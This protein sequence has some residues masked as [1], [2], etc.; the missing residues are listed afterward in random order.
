MEHPVSCLIMHQF[1]ILCLIFIIFLVYIVFLENG[2][3]STETSNIT[4]FNQIGF[5]FS[6]VLNLLFDWH[7]P[8]E[9][10]APMWVHR[11]R[12]RPERDIGTACNGHTSSRTQLP[13]SGTRYQTSLLQPTRSINSRIATTQWREDEH[14]WTNQ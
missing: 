12:N 3:W 2:S 8:L 13:T 7:A 14:N 10:R 1:S 4:T 5:C 11:E 6:L 9:T